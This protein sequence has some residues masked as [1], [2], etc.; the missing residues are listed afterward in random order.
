MKRVMDILSDCD[1]TE[2]VTFTMTLVNKVRDT[3][4]ACL[5]ALSGDVG[6]RS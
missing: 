1:E 4:T 6:E 3:K 2:L 5:T